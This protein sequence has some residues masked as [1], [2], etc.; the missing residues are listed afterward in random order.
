MTGFN[1][2]IS[3]LC[4]IYS[5]CYTICVAAQIIDGKK[6]AAKLMHGAI[7]ACAALREMDVVP[8]LAVTIVGNDPASHSYIRAKKQACEQAGI[9]A[10]DTHFSEHIDHDT[11]V[12]HIVEQNNDPTIHAILVQLP[13]P[14]HINTDEITRTIAP[15]K[16]VDG[17]HPDNLG[18]LMAGNPRYVPCTPLG[19]VRMLMECDIKIAGAE[20]VVVGRSMIVG[21]P[22]A[23]LLMGKSEYG[24]ATVTV[25]HS[26]TDALDNVTRRADILI[27][28]SG[29]P[30]LITAPM[31]KSGAAVIDVGVNRIDDSDAPKGYRLCGDVDFDSVKNIA[32]FISPVPGGVGPLTISMLVQNTLL[33]ARLNTQHAQAT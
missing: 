17:F 28:A 31:V 3:L 33:A 6:I 16:D 25:A 10:T 30:R 9:T 12:K 13:L 29:V 22:L 15:L 27:A 5:V 8:A 1:Q 14:A 26:K 23:L 32:S 4:L 7:H 24:N 20:V 21:A 11:L 2:M 18:L 19:I